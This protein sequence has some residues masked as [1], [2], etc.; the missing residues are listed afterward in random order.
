MSRI[1]DRIEREAGVPGLASVLDRIPPTDLQSL[2][3]EVS[4]RRC[5]RRTP[6]DLARDRRAN[7]FVTAGAA[8]YRCLLGWERMVIS[9][10]GSERVCTAFAAG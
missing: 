9:G 8:P 10:I 2:L 1:I 5:A 3:L 4:R 6:A 7:R